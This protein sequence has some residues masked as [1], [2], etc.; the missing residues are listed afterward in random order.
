MIKYN[1]LNRNALMSALL[2]A[3]LLSFP[4]LSWAD[5]SNSGVESSPK[6]GERVLYNGNF[7]NSAHNLKNAAIWFAEEG[8]VAAQLDALI[9]LA[10]AYRLLGLDEYAIHIL[11]DALPLA[12]KMNNNK[13]TATVL[14]AL[15]R[16]HAQN[17]KVSLA[18]GIGVGASKSRSIK[19][20]KKDLAEL[21]LSEAFDLAKAGNDSALLASVYN[22]K[23]IMYA[24]YGNL[25]DARLSFLE[26][27]SLAERFGHKEIAANASVNCAAVAIQRKEYLQA[28]SHAETAYRLFG[29]LEP[30]VEK[31]RGLI[32]TGQM[33][34]QIAGFIPERAVQIRQLARDA[35]VESAAISEKY[36]DYRSVSY[37]LGYLGQ[38]YEEQTEFNEA[39]HLTR[40]ALFAAQQVNA[41]ELLSTWEWQ[42][43]RIARMVGDNENAVA[44]YRQA[45]LN[46]QSVK[47]G[48]YTGCTSSSLSYKDSIEPI[49]KGLTE[50]LFQK[51]SNT[52]DRKE[53]EQYLLEARQTVESLRV[54][55]IRDYFKNSCFGDRQSKLKGAETFS[56]NTAIIYMISFPEK[57]E[58]LVSFPDGVKR[59]TVSNIN[60]AIFSDVKAFR[61]NLTVLT[62]D[63]LVS[64]KKL[65]N[66]LIRP[67]E[68]DLKRHKINTLVIIPDDIFRTIPFAALHDGNDFLINKY[69]VATSLGMQLTEPPSVKNKN[70]TMLAAGISESVRNY[71]ALPSVTSEINEIQKMFDGE[72]L[73]NKDFSISS[74]KEKVDQ[75]KY[76][77]IHLASHGEF[78][79]DANNSF[80]VAWDGQL[81]IDQFGRLVKSTQYKD[82]P[83]DLITLSACKTAVG[84]DK[85]VLGLAGVAIKSGAMSSLATLWEVDDKATS[86]LV[87]EFYRQ[88]KNNT[89]SKVQALQKAQLLTIQHQGHPYYWSPF[90]LIGS[91]L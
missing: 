30:G 40:R 70:I 48:M 75:K 76:S 50:L 60:N 33:F 10:E 13:T 68:S 25:D 73:L 51:S 66:S 53:A 23:G 2:L 27:F 88:L 46:L 62:D 80:I 89:Q 31:T 12:R 54:A 91:W 79:N 67:L 20:T 74:L 82:E 85:A 43:G 87:V 84:D 57:I 83:L 63:Y 36:K 41:K 29:G 72:M 22:N 3:I 11:E 39:R 64:S 15:G 21:Y 1:C 19:I 58:L 59:I 5:K 17:A 47:Q 77:I 14:N 8:N 56:D 78:S 65:Y 37:A 16:L 7:E 18:P 44:A 6:K 38:L 81:T 61:N 52:K 35:F 24:A 45:I 34:R 69:A 9:E 71:P 49:Y 55:E 4:Y 32:A 42:L 90:I 28:S 26:S 86:E